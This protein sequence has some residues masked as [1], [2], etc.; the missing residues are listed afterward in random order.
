MLPLGGTYLSVR[1]SLSCYSHRYYTNYVTNESQWTHPDDH[2]YKSVISILQHGFD[3]RGQLKNM[4]SSILYKA[5]QMSTQWQGPYYDGD[6]AYYHNLVN[7][8]SCWGD[9]FSSLNYQAEICIVVPR[10][11]IIVHIEFRLNYLET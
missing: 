7:S 6:K 10:C 9:P 2:V 8:K 4:Y 11:A 5:E 3:I 1:K